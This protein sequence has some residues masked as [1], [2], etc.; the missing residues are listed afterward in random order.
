MEESGER[1]GKIV[2]SMNNE[3]SERET[4]EERISRIIF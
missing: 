1:K 3:N 2:R 4:R